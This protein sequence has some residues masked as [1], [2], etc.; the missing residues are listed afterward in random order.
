VNFPQTILFADTSNDAVSSTIHGFFPPSSRVVGVKLIAAA[1][2]TIFP[3]STLPV[4]NI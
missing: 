1:L 4:K 2:A 3:T